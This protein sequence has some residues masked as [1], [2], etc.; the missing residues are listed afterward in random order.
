MPVG[1][2]NV[3]VYAMDVYGFEAASNTV[4]F[5]TTSET[6]PFPIIPVVVAVSILAIIAVLCIVFW[7]KKP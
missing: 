5:I 7:K 3:T 1:V 4:T 6:T 2:H